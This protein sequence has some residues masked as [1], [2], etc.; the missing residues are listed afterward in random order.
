MNYINYSTQIIKIVRF[1]DVD[2]ILI[3]SEEIERRHQMTMMVTQLDLSFLSI[4]WGKIS[5][6]S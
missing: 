6:C 3:S 5:S 4:C 1:G 2:F